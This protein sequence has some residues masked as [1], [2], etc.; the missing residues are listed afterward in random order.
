MK[1]IIGYQIVSNDGKNELP[2]AFFSFEVF[3]YFEVIELWLSLEKANPENGE[4]RWV[5]SPVFEGDIEEPTF[6]E[7]I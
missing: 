6:I 5:I 2:D 1:K 4:F 3:I 7:Y